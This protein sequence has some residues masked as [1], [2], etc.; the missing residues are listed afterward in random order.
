MSLI[1][2]VH[3]AIDFVLIDVLY[4]WRKCY[5]LLGVMIVLVIVQKRFSKG[6]LAPEDLLP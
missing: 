1:D 4:T 6:V 3:L 2:M 5:A